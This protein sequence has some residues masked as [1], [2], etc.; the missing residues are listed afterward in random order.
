MF[1]YCYYYY[2]FYYYLKNIYS[3]Q[4][5]PTFIYYICQTRIPLFILTYIFVADCRTSDS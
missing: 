2:Y 3:H 1:C 5:G 4:Y